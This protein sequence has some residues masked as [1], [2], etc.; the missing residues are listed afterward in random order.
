MH[1]QPERPEKGHER[2]SLW[3]LLSAVLSTSP[4]GEA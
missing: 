3:E 4:V 1:L 2:L